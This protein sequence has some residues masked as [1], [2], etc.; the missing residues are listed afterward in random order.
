MRPRMVN[1]CA[2]YKGRKKHD[3]YLFVEHEDDFT[4]VPQTLL[5]MLGELELVMTLDLAERRHLAQANPQQIAQL[6]QS[7]GYYLQLPPS[8]ETLQ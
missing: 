5:D 3:T 4:R 1:K 2:V 6:L 8:I 7:Q